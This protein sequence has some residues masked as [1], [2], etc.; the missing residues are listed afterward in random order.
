MF[1]SIG[2]LRLFR[3]FIGVLLFFQLWTIV[4]ITYTWLTN[5][6]TLTE[7]NKSTMIIWIMIKISI[8]LIVGILFFGLKFI[9]NKLHNN[10]KGISHPDKI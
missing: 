4:E 5:L 6:S 1:F 7:D 9:V 8:L 10:W 2:L 3:A